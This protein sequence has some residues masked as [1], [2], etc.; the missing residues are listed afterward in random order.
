MGGTERREGGEGE[1]KRE[2]RDRGMEGEEEEAERGANERG[3][4]GGDNDILINACPG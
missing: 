2:W 1:K 3:G 4:V